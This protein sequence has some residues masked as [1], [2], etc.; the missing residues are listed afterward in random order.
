MLLTDQVYPKAYGGGGVVYYLISKANGRPVL[1]EGWG[2]HSY[3]INNYSQAHLNETALQNRGYVP[4]PL[5]A[6]LAAKL[7]QFLEGNS[8]PN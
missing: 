1:V 5:S 7:S 2:E 3:E 8:A 6:A 4:M